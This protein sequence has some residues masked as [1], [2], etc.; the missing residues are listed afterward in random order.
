M[1]TA[2]RV[3]KRTLLPEMRRQQTLGKEVVFRGAMPPSPSR[4]STKRLEERGVKY[5]IRIPVNDSLERDISGLL[6][7]PVGRPSHKPVI[8][9]KSF[10]YQAGSWKTPRRVV[11][12]VEFHSGELFPR[13]GFIVTN[14]SLPAG[15]WCGSTTS[16]ERRS[17]GSRKASRR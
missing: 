1:C 14:L 11:A 13:V 4:R 6:T 2:P 7:R 5:A 12:K 15:P 10:L 9:Y 16:G 17:N 8:W 3:G